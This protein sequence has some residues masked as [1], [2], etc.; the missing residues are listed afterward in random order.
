MNVDSI[1]T[2]LERALGYIIEDVQY[3]KSIVPDTVL[4]L[5][6][7]GAGTIVYANIKEVIF[8]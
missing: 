4:L 7:T 6:S 5:P 2:I 1:K 3:G 8:G